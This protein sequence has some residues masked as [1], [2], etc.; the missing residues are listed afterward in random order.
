MSNERIHVLKPSGQILEGLQLLHDA[1][2][3]AREAEMCEEPVPEQ[4]DENG[5]IDDDEIEM[6]EDEASP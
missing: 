2:I 1:R 6:E 4:D 5:Y 3:L